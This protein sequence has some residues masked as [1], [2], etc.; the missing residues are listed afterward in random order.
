MYNPSAWEDQSSGP[1]ASQ[2]G[3]LK[4]NPMGITEYEAKV[5][6]DDD[7]INT[8]IC[9]LQTAEAMFSL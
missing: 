2:P 5:K 3:S 1:T 7:P 4:R 8:G 6:L 9:N